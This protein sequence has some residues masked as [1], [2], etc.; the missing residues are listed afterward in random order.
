M[1]DT[2]T[3]ALPAERRVPESA[4]DERL[5]SPQVAAL[6]DGSFE[7]TNEK[8]NRPVLI[9]PPAAQQI[10]LGGSESPRSSAARTGDLATES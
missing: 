4:A 3:G 2:F 1:R 8:D 7:A 10:A 6:A 9:P 5:Q